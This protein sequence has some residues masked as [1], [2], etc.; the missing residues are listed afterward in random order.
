MLS[1]CTDPSSRQ[2]TLSSHPI[3]SY[4]NQVLAFFPLAII[5]VTKGFQFQ[6][7]QRNQFRMVSDSVHSLLNLH[8]TETNSIQTRKTLKKLGSGHLSAPVTGDSIISL[9]FSAFGATGRKSPN[10]KRAVRIGRLR[11]MNS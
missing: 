10:C 1:S 4:R 3:L 11:R 2:I 9:H 8:D 5:L 6:S 7:S